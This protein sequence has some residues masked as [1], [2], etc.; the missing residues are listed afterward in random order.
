MDGEPSLRNRALQRLVS[1]EISRSEYEAILSEIDRLQAASAPVPQPSYIP[2]PADREKGTVAGIPI[3]PALKPGTL[4][5][6][7]ELKSS[8]RGGMGEVWKAWDAKADRWVAVKFLPPELRGNAD[9]IARIRRQ[10]GLVKK[11]SHSHICTPF[12]LNEHPVWGWYE[13]MDWIEGKTLKELLDE[14]ES[15]LPLDR[16]IELLGPAANALDYAHGESVLH[17]DVKPQNIMFGRRSGDKDAKV[18]VIDFGLAAEVRG[19]LSRVSKRIDGLSGTPQYLAPELWNEAPGSP[20]SDQYALGV[21][22][23]ELLAGGPPFK[24]DNIPILMAR[25]QSASVP[26]ISS[27]PTDPMAVLQRALAKKPGERFDKC[28]VFIRTLVN[29]PKLTPVQQP[30]VP[31]LSRPDASQKAPPDQRQLPRSNP[32]ASVRSG[33]G[34]MSPTIPV[35]DLSPLKPSKVV[36]GTLVGAVGA[37]GFLF[38]MFLLVGAI[39]RPGQAPPRAAPPAPTGSSDTWS[40]NTNGSA[41]QGDQP[42]PLRSPFSKSEAEAGQKSWAAYLGRQV[43]EKNSIGMEFALIPPGSFQMGSPTSEPGRNSDEGPV[44]V[45]LTRPYW[46][47][48]TEVTRGQ[49]KAVMGREPWG[50]QSGTDYHPATDVSWE[51]AQAFF[52]RLSILEGN[53]WTYRLPTDAEWEWACRGGTLTAYWFG[54]ELNG[55]Q[56]NCN[57]NYRYGTIQKGPYKQGTTAVG[58]YDLNPFGLWDMHGNV[59]EWCADRHHEAL[60]GGENPEAT[61]SGSVRVIRGG[62]WGD[63]AVDCRSANRARYWPGSRYNYLG[64]RVLAVPSPR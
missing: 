52:T 13:V 16:V 15:K 6:K 61:S 38:L 21:T 62:G 41:T 24:S 12:D 5:D 2:G 26:V 28:S 35:A 22:A 40:T 27:L 32:T 17:R 7:Y 20:E 64:F 36:I 8:K 4:L 54:N 59:W 19:S 48:R 30:L 53:G 34:P 9:E 49:W 39:F 60:P 55:T 25:A 50:S 43:Y 1:G 51:C 10:F 46:L 11:L 3:P 37:I 63:G 29:P 42:S 45:T 14:A 33:S 56:A 47:G 23:Y 57:G 58:S 44:S 31:Q 18:W